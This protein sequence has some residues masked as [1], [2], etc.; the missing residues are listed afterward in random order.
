MYA[1]G[2]FIVDGKKHKVIICVMIELFKMMRWLKLL[3]KPDELPSVVQAHL[4]AS[5][6][7]GF[8]DLTS[9][10]E[11]TWKWERSSS[12]ITNIYATVWCI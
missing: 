9:S 7:P 2:V 6:V 12:E 11:R 3:S 5:Q 10:V 4:E 8:Q 1:V